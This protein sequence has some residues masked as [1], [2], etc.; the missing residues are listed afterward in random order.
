LR[1]YPGD[2]DSGAMSSYYVWGKLGLF[3]NAGQDV[4]LLN[5]PAFASM[6][7][8]RP[9]REA[10]RVRRTGKGDYVAGV[11][12]NGVALTRSWLRQADID[13]PCLLEF[14]M[15]ETPTAWARDAEPPPSL[16]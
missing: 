16:P 15:S 5:G 4:Y 8:R 6:T 3:P 7:V 12:L 14:T 11:K 10:L 1:A 9:G 13:G 2:D